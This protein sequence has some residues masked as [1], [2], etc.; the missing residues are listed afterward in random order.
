MGRAID[1]AGML[2]ERIVGS[3]LRRVRTAV[4]ARVQAYDPA[5]QTAT[6]LPLVGEQDAADGSTRELEPVPLSRMPVLHLGSRKRGI[7]HGLEQGDTGVVLVRHRSHA[8]IDGGATGPATPQSTARL[9]IGQGVLLPGYVASGAGQP[10]AHYRSDGQMV[11]YLDSGEALHVGVSTASI[12]L[13]RADRV[14]AQL[15]QIRDLLTGGGVPQWVP[16]PNDGG[17]ALL[18]AASALWTA[19][20]TSVATSRVKVDA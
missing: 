13:A 11:A 8:E 5:T 20:S 1:A 16:V 6:A 19:P 9:Q 2:A 10:A 18:A 12:L 17:A 14:D 4:V 3:L 7:T 15:Q